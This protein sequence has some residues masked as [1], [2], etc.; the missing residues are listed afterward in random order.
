M[1][2]MNVS[3]K[4]EM[5]ANGKVVEFMI[6]DEI[7]PDAVKFDWET[8]REVPDPSDTSQRYFNENLAGLTA[9]DTVRLYINSWGGDVKEALGIYNALRRCPARV[10]AYI[11][12]Y[13]AS[14]ASII[15]MAADKIIMPH[16]TCMM[17]HNAAWTAYGNPTE[18]RKSADD[19][20]IINT[21]AISSYTARAG[22]KLP[23][24]ELRQ[25]L[26]AETWLS[27]DD[28]IKYGLADEYGDTDADTAQ[29][30]QTYAAVAAAAGETVR[31]YGR[32]PEY[33]AAACLAAAAQSTAGGLQQ[34][35]AQKVTPPAAPVETPH[36]SIFKLLENMTKE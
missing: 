19:L 10:E 3:H 22:D 17:I 28:C 9:A 26:D 25:M 4:V 13:A 33:L 11:D 8:W 16:N 29:M 20:E 24:S 7:R 18:L 27:A 15:A 36:S 31:A 12:G 21:A 35:P 2:E 23:E 14:A 32:P 34:T 5:L 1:L 6:R 30:A